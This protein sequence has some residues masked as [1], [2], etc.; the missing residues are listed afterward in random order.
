MMQENIYSK[1]IMD[2]SI[3]PCSAVWGSDGSVSFMAK[4]SVHVYIPNLQNMSM[5][6]VR[7]LTIDRPLSA[8][9]TDNGIAQVFQLNGLHVTNKS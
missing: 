3:F 7:W 2:V 5:Y 9:D 8:A 6:G 1:N 4:G